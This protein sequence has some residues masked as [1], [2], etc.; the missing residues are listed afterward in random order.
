MTRSSRALVEV[1]VA[2]LL[3]GFIGPFGKAVLILLAAVPSKREII[4]GLIIVSAALFES[5]RSRSF[6][7]TTYP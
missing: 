6:E 7:H 1:H 5:L 4:G 2:T 3:Y